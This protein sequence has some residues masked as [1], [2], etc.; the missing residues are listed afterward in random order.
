MW[1]ILVAF[2]AARVNVLLSRVAAVRWGGWCGCKK[3]QATA[4]GRGK[5]TKISRKLSA[6]FTQKQQMKG[7]LSR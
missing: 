5:D 6:K 3:G 2:G 1:G 4:S 7:S